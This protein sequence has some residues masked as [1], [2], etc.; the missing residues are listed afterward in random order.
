MTVIESTGICSI[1]EEHPADVYDLRGDRVR[2]GVTTLTG[3][4][5]G[6]YIVNGSKLVIK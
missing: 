2:S 3:L 5:K 6:V 1:S 4:A